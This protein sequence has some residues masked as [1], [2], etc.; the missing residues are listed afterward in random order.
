MVFAV[1]QALFQV[2]RVNVIN[3]ILTITYEVGTVI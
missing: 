2:T 3:L 1:C